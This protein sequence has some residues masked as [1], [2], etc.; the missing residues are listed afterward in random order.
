MALTGAGVAQG[1]CELVKGTIEE[2]GWTCNVCERG[3][4]SGELVWSCPD[5]DWDGC[6]PCLD[7]AQKEEQAAVQRQA[8]EEGE[9]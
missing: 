8:E 5:C 9:G 2:A 6:K 4:E 3:L 7:E 1:N